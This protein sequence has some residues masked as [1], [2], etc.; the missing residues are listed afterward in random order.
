MP[1][2]GCLALH[3]VNLNLKKWI[4]SQSSSPAVCDFFWGGEGMNLLFNGFESSNEE[5]MVR[6][7]EEEVL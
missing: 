1:C 5:D 7:Q 6:Q 4:V 3:R 2:S